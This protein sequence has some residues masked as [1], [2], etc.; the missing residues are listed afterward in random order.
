MIPYREPINRA[1]C[2]L[3]SALVPLFH[4]MAMRKIKHM[5][6]TLL[7]KTAEE[8]ADLINLVSRE[9]ELARKIGRGGLATFEKYYTVDS[10]MPRM[11]DQIESCVVGNKSREDL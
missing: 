3:I 10:V 1:L 4:S 6:N 11:L 2:V 7:G 5:P 9:P 8:I